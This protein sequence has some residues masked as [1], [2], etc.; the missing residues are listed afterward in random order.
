M[1]T[2][3]G[4]TDGG[5]IHEEYPRRAPSNPTKRAAKT[6]RAVVGWDDV[7]CRPIYRGNMIEEGSKVLLGDSQEDDARRAAIAPCN[8]ATGTEGP[9]F[10]K[11]T[12]HQQDPSR[13]IRSYG[14]SRKHRRLDKDPDD[15]FLSVASSMPVVRE[16]ARD[17]FTVKNKPE[18]DNTENDDKDVQATHP[19][20]VSPGRGHHCPVFEVHEKKLAQVDTCLTPSVAPIPSISSKTSLSDVKEFFRKLDSEHTLTI[21][22]ELST[23]PNHK[24][25]LAGRSR[26]STRNVLTQEYSEYAAACDAS[27]VTPLSKEAYAANRLHFRSDFYD[28]F[29]DYGLS[30][31]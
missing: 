25:K 23:S 22:T 31:V 30:D 13:R 12:K 4:N 7:R 26:R 19:C 21:S 1:P 20:S 17:S 28:G 11:A 8:T 18:S 24:I 5:L 6:G 14:G 15:I 9:K 29:L 27:S 3:R 2:L 10:G 16:F